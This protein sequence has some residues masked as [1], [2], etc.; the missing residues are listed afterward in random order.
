MLRGG[1]PVLWFAL[2]DR[3]KVDFTPAAGDWIDRDTMR[4][5]LPK[6]NLGVLEAT[7]TWIVDDP[8]EFSELQGWL[9]AEISGQIRQML[10]AVRPLPAAVTAFESALP[11][12]LPR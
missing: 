10:T 9:P 1:G 8:A 5:A 6:R 7:G 2:R 11:E 3:E 12:V 4:H